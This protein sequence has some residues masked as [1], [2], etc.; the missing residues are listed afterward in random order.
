MT[1]AL[2][3]LAANP[4]DETADNY[5]TTAYTSQAPLAGL[6]T[7]AVGDSAIAEPKSKGAVSAMWVVLAE[8]AVRFA[9]FGSFV[10]KADGGEVSTPGEY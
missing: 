9:P 4:T 8:G 3:T 10:A 7:R 1:A 5:F 6:F 2:D